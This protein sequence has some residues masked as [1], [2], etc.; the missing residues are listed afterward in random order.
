MFPAY[1]SNYPLLPG[2]TPVTSAKRKSTKEDASGKDGM[3]T[4]E[5]GIDIAA[6][7]KKVPGAT[8][9]QLIFSPTPQ[10]V[11]FSNIDD[12]NNTTHNN[13]QA[14]RVA[15][16]KQPK[17]S[18]VHVGYLKMRVGIATT[19]VR[20]AEKAAIGD[21]DAPEIRRRRKNTV[22]RRLR[23]WVRW[24]SLTHLIDFASEILNPK[25]TPMEGKNGCELVAETDESG[26]RQSQKVDRHQTK[27]GGVGKKMPADTTGSIR[28]SSRV[29]TSGVSCVVSWCGVEVTSFE[30]CPQTGVP[31]TPGEC[32]LA[33]P[34]G[35]EWRTC[36]LVVEVVATEQFM[37]H[38][39][40]EH[41]RE[42][43]WHLG[44]NDLRDGGDNTSQ[45]KR[46]ESETGNIYDRFVA[47][48]QGQYL[49]GMV[50]VSWQVR[51]SGTE[52]DLDTVVT[53][54]IIR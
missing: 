19:T 20:V 13:H 5:T 52:H 37:K 44:C 23:L 11:N 2:Q 9:S 40:M 22:K 51:K 50:V 28:C 25:K 12:D 3:V 38:R 42:Q 7:A 24:I 39:G 29:Q 14:E 35:M 49:L 21:E 43:H 16:A 8:S 31:L 41:A 6:E 47:K 27:H 15:K 36:R 46:E 30:I 48:D 1:S 53:S 54:L 34:R 26:R 33:L 10:H 45:G 18:S 4:A 32:L 17:R